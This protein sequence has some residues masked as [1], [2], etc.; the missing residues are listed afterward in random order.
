MGLFDG[1]SSLGSGIANAGQ[2]LLSGLVGNQNQLTQTP[3]A[4]MQGTP[5]I[6]PV[7]DPFSGPVPAGAGPIAPASGPIQQMPQ[8]QQAGL[9]DRMGTPDANGRTFGD[10]LFA[11]GSIL[12][13]DSGGAASY[14]QNQR[15]MQDAENERQRQQN[16]AQAGMKA[17]SDNVDPV[18]GR[19]NTQGYLK[20]MAAGGG[21]AGDLSQ[22]LAV[23]KALA[24]ETSV[25]TP[26]AEGAYNVSRNQDT[27]AAT[28]STLV[29]K[30][31][32]KSPVLENGQPN[33]P[34][35]KAMALQEQ[36]KSDALQPNRVQ[37]KNIHAPQRGP[38]TFL[39]PRATAG[40]PK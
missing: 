24:P 27:G 29:P 12:Q 2:G 19:L 35:L 37:L 3:G 5:Q 4:T 22:G 30:D 25:I 6:N 8:F 7:A 14:L 10:K 11:A 23:R 40:L 38:T 36:M 28:S 1:L 17:I 18:T 13:G 39:P 34:Y 9:L 26:G 21:S 32:T 15:T 33:L 16:I 31:W 20:A